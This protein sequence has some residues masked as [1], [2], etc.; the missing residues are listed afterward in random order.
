VPAPSPLPRVEVLDVASGARV[1]FAD[2]IP[3]ERP[4]L[5][6]FWAPH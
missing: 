1:Q 4:V 5:L 2:L 6:W 3:A